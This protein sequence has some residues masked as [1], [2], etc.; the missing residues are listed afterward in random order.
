M[1]LRPIGA[2]A[3]PGFGEERSRPHAYPDGAGRIL[4]RRT[5]TTG[6]AM[7]AVVAESLARA[8]A[9]AR[10]RP[11]PPGVRETC[12]R[13]LVDVAGLC[14]AARHEP[15]VRACIASWE[16]QG[17]CT[18]I[19]HARALDAAGAAFVN[20]TAAHGEDFD[21]TFEGGPVHAGA[22][23]VPALLAAAER[24]RLGGEDL[25]FG[26]AVG[27]EVMCRASLVAPRRIH[28]AGFHP[29]AVLGAMGA[30]AGVAAACRFD[31]KAFASAQGI[32]G[33]MA[34]GII[35]YLAEGTSTKRLH[36]GWAAQAGLR[37][38]ALARAGFDG[39]RTVWEGEH[40]FL[41]AFA[42][43]REGRWGELLDGFGERWVAEAL[44]FK[45]YACGTMIHP[46]I[47][48]ARR[49]AA[50]GI[51][52]AA[53]VAIECETAEGI[54]HR[55]WEPL[56]AKRR[57][58]NAY[59]AKFS[60]P[61]G[62]AFGLLRGAAGLEAF[63]DANAADPG[64]RELAAKVAYKVDPANPY[65]REYTG[66]LRATLRDGRVVEERQPHLRGGQHE[67]LS[68]SE[69]E[70]KFRDN[71]RH[72]GWSDALATAWLAWVE[73]AFDAP[74]ALERFRA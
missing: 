34:S 22:V 49:L 12:A 9:H 58:P 6:E 53:I 69:L 39:P 21:D 63:S 27:V 19:G 43:T 40:G 73:R 55:L 62:V 74:V 67:P 61:F 11:M 59:A 60:I 29:T 14:V 45:P 50:R 15:Y 31:E 65:P 64:I 8:V 37:A 35:E 36:P 26:I 17:G 23:I 48:C 32:A 68:R 44:A 70:A 42:N 51:A 33:S 2:Q 25:L 13:L 72:G 52:A 4:R 16:A 20:G 30:A 10:P 28:Q 38:A 41:H 66:H 18:A 5:T 57:P 24:E 47:D 1:T 56:E 54:V 46:Y 71:C 3:P 7:A